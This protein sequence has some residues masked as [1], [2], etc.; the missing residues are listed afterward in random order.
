MTPDWIGVDRRVQGNICRFL[1]LDHL[2]A[3]MA[4]EYMGGGGEESV[5]WLLSRW[6]L[7]LSREFLL[8]YPDRQMDR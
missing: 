2:F 4:F 7:Q 5:A 6:M 8:G 3:T 1:G